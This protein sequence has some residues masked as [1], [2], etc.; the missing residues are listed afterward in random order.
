MR[1]PRRD[2][3]NVACL[4]VALS[5][6]I[7]IALVAGSCMLKLPQIYNISGGDTTGLSLATFIMEVVG[8]S[9]FVVYNIEKGFSFT[10]WGENFFLL[11]QSVI[12][13]FMLVAYRKLWGLRTWA[14]L[15]VYVAGLAFVLSGEMEARFGPFAL[16]YVTVTS[17]MI[18]F[19]VSRGAQIL[20]N[21]NESGTGQLSAITTF[22]AAVG[23][24]L[25]MLTILQEVDDGFVLFGCVAAVITNNILFGQILFYNYCAKKTKTE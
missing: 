22:L 18:L 16:G 20:K 1:A 24:V 17:N 4:K 6:A 13:V 11:I 5:K 14:G 19:P 2:F 12:I 25:R 7:G 9:V 8:Y 23:P 3:A 15:G 21:Y 10:T